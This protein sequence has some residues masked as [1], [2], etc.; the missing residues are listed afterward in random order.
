MVGAIFCDLLGLDCISR[1]S[2]IFVDGQRGSLR[3]M[4]DQLPLLKSWSWCYVK[5]RLTYAMPVS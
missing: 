3:R 2:W 5:R 1:A 4:L